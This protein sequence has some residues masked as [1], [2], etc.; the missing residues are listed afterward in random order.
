MEQSQ[1]VDYRRLIEEVVDKLAPHNH[2]LAGH[3]CKHAWATRCPR[4]ESLRFHRSPYML[5]MR[6]RRLDVASILGEIARSL[7]TVPFGF[8]KYR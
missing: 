8:R 1:K 4:D 6:L 3:L 5:Q 2:S 7:F